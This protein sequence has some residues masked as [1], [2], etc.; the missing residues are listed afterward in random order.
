M[1]ILSSRYGT[2]FGLVEPLMGKD[3]PLNVPNSIFGIIFYLL[4]FLLGKDS[5]YLTL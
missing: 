5:H 3:S 2:G 1:Q 4:M